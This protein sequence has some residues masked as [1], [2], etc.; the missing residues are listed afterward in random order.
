MI[1]SEF[2]LQ[3]T[4][5]ERFQRLAIADVDDSVLYHPLSRPENDH[6]EN[7]DPIEFCELG[8]VTLSDIY[9]KV[10]LKSPAILPELRRTH[11][12]PDQ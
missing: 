2:R 5:H 8:I 11:I 6:K 3:P 12:I 4:T 1:D 10:I 9:Q 7:A